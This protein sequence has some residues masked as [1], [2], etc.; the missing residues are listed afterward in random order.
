MTTY[1]VNVSSGIA[2]AE[3]LERTI[4]TYGKD[5]TIGVFADV[6]GNNDSPHAG[7][8]EDNY[9][10]LADI[11]RYFDFSIVRIVEGR[12]IWQAMFDARAITLPVGPARVAKCSS[13]LKRIP[14]DSWI[15]ANFSPATTVRVVGLDWTEPHRIADYERAVAPWRCWFPLNEAPYVDRRHLVEKWQ[16]RGI[17]PPR[18]YEAG[19]LHANCGGFCVRAGLNHFAR[20]YHWNRERYFY[21][22]EYEKQFRET[23]NDKATIV[24]LRRG[25]VTRPITLYELADLIEA[26]E[27]FNRVIDSDDGCGCFAPVVQERMD[28][29]LLNADIK[30]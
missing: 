16:A 10:F 28:D 27:T 13:D 18:L 22:A 4:A 12:H 2:S 30:R 6:K 23:I 11:E 1:I 25:G 17:Q 5:N 21:H 14:V 29:I 26:G 8:D 7:E 3:A 19:F 9:R 24:R 20:L 15:A